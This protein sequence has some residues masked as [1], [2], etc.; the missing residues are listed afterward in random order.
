MALV[1]LVLVSAQFVYIFGNKQSD[2]ILHVAYELESYHLNQLDSEFVGADIQQLSPAMNSLNFN[3][4]I[5]QEIQRDGYTLIGA[6]YCLIQGQI[7]A[8]LNLLNKQGQRA[9]LYLTKA[10]DELSSLHNKQ[11]QRGDL[12]VRVWLED[13]LFYSL[14]Q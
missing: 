9:T 13:G 10:N 12:I 2:L 5:P 6:S 4:N 3:L 8:Q 11:Q 1:L 14:V 7:A